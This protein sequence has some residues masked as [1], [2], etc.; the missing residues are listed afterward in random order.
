LVRDKR[1]CLPGS[2]RT[3]SGTR[4]CRWH[5]TSTCPG[6]ACTPRWQPCWTEP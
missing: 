3:S 6:V 5:R 4:R 1:V 2:V